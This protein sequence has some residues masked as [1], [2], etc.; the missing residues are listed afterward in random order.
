LALGSNQMVF[1]TKLKL[2]RTHY[3]A[4]K[5]EVV[6]YPIYSVNFNWRLKGSSEC[7]AIIKA[8]HLP[9]DRLQRGLRQRIS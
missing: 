4:L 3:A 1:D 5:N 2:L 6:P 9:M 8:S 7:R